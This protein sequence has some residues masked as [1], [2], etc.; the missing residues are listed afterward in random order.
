MAD[1]FPGSH[2]QLL[3]NMF[4]F[5]QYNLLN[6]ATHIKLQN[7]IAIISI[8]I[9]TLG[10]RNTFSIYIYSHIGNKLKHTDT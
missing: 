4:L 5:H 8:C 1:I 7:V 9:R 2:R 6:S 10:M 3:H